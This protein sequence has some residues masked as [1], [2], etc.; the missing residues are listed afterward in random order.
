MLVGHL[1][2]LRQCINRWHYVPP[3]DTVDQ[4][5]IMTWEET[6]MVYFKVI[7]LKSASWGGINYEWDERKIV[8]YF[9]VY[10]G[11]KWNLGD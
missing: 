9:M 2:M 8:A 11:P 5:W 3:R 6:D 7:T 10:S 1:A 4:L